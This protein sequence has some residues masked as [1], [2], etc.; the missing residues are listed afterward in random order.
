MALWPAQARVIIS[1]LAEYVGA[2][3]NDLQEQLLHQQEADSQKA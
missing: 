2:I 3:V 1:D